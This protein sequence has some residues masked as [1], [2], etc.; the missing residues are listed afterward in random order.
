MAN[1][2][3]FSRQTVAMAERISGG[4]LPI[5]VTLPRDVTLPSDVTLASEPLTFDL[6]EQPHSPSRFSRKCPS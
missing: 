4:L 6:A 3:L 5:D 2:G 1:C